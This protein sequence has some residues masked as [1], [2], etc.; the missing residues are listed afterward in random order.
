MRLTSLIL[1]TLLL[2]SGAAFAVEKAAEVDSDNHPASTSS[3]TA[4]NDGEDC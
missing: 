1:A 4:S 2:A 3:T